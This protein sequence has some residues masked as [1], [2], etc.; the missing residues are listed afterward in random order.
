MLVMGQDAAGTPRP[1]KVTP[2]GEL[3][4]SVAAASYSVIVLDASA[5]EPAGN[6]YPTSGAAAA[7]AKDAGPGSVIVIIG[8]VTFD[9]VEHDITGVDKIVGLGNATPTITIPNGCTIKD[10]FGDIEFENVN[11]SFGGTSN[12]VITAPAGGLTLTLGQFASIFCT[13]TATKGFLEASAGTITMNCSWSNT[14]QGSSGHQVIK[15]SGSA[16][17][18]LS[19]GNLGTLAANSITGGGDQAV[20]VADASKAGG[21]LA[22]TISHTQTGLTNPQWG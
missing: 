19:I 14:I 12:P 1:L 22:A 21:F 18:N 17:L 2:G 15:L 20:S 3:V 4:M 6:V 10:D 7:A 13:N 16:G 9:A 11:L 8:D 5:P